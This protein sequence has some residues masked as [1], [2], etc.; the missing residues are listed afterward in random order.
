MPLASKFG[1]D[2]TKCSKNREEK[3]EIPINEENREPKVQTR[4]GP[5][6]HHYTKTL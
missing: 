6:D 2:F 4:V 3:I 5:K 1:S